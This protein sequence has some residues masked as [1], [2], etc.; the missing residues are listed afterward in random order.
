MANIIKK[1]IKLVFILQIILHLAES[2][3]REYKVG[4]AGLKKVFIEPDQ[5]VNHIEC[6]VNVKLK[7]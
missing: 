4:K 6:L 7:K 5:K 2:Y 1:I 3:G